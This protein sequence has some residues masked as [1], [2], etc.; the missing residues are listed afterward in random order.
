MKDLALFGLAGVLQSHYTASRLI[1]HAFPFVHKRCGN[2]NIFL[3]LDSFFLL[4]NSYEQEYSK[5]YSR[6]DYPQISLQISR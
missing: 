5:F 6:S 3:H 2:V 1:L 4:T